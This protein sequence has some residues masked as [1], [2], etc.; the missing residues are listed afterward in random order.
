M[1]YYNRPVSAFVASFVGS[2]NVL[3]ARVVDP[4]AGTLSV[5]GQ[6][7]AAAAALTHA[8]GQPVRVSL[9][10]E[11]ISLTNGRPDSNRLAGTVKTV[12]FLGSIVRI[13]LRLDGSELF[14]DTFNNPHLSLPGVGERVSVW[15][16]REACLVGS[17]GETAWPSG[18]I[19][20]AIRR[21]IPR[22]LMNS[23]YSVDIPASVTISSKSDS[24]A[25]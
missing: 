9:R 21:A 3:D 5:E 19:H 15:F 25:K 17:E 11:M 23:E 6:Q 4:A 13:F 7:I 24:S 12:V 10:P 22:F 2:L 18:P 8:S 14:L 1:R 16:P 20:Q